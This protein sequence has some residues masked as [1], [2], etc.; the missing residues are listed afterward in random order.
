M[1]SRISLEALRNEP[2][3]VRL[4]SEIATRSLHSSSLAKSAN[5]KRPLQMTKFSSFSY[6][7][8][9]A[10]LIHTIEVEEK[11]EGKACNFAS[12]HLHFRYDQPIS[13]NH[14]HIRI[15][16]VIRFHLEATIPL[17]PHLDIDIFEY[18]HIY[19]YILQYRQQ[20]LYP[21]CPA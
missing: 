7:N 15:T 18:F 17:F 13:G 19:N 1:L 16:S 14:L 12:F 21:F 2:S 20:N 3:P 6:L 8:N 5:C 11:G 4:A 10:P 9:I